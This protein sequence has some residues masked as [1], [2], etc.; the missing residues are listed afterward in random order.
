MAK[1][2][3]FNNVFSKFLIPFF[4]FFGQVHFHFLNL[5]N[6]HRGQWNTLSLLTNLYSSLNILHNLALI[7]TNIDNFD[8]IKCF[9]YTYTHLS[10]SM[11]VFISDHMHTQMELLFFFLI[12]KIM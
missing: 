11:Q 2:V 3:Q 10:S 12:R 8:N 1:S 5:V 6:T 4:F 7:N 9:I